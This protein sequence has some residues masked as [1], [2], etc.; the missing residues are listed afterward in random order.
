MK[1]KIL[2]KTETGKPLHQ[3]APALVRTLPH[4]EY[5]VYLWLLQ[6]YS[7]DW[8]AESLGLK[9]RDV[10]TLAKNV[11]KILGV[12]DQRDLVRYYFVPANES[13]VLQ[14]EELANSMASYTDQCARSEPESKEV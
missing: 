1:Q 5:Q 14:G 7:L 9:K 13:P 3:D 12:G 4:Q 8:I 2:T 6:A 10:K 11:Y